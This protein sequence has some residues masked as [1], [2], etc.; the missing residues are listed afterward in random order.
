MK[1]THEQ[2]SDDVVIKTKLGGDVRRFL[3]SR[4]GGFDSLLS[5]LNTIY[6]KL[7]ANCF[8]KVRDQTTT[9]LQFA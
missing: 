2:S 9:E 3:L 4:E 1:R 7:P 8:L 6:D 5:T